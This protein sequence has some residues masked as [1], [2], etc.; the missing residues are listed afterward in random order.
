MSARD[1]IALCQRDLWRFPD[2]CAAFVRS[3]TNRCGVILTGNAKDICAHISRAPQRAWN[4]RDAAAWATDGCLVIGVLAAPGH[5]HV[6]IVVDGPFAEGRYPYA[7][8]GQYH[9]SQ[10]PGKDG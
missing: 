3:V 5:G 2:A 10:S 9:G 7:F 1:I 6:V 8:W 4:G